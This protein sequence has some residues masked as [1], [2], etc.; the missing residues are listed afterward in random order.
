[1]ATIALI[2]FDLTQFANVHYCRLTTWHG[3][4][5]QLFMIS[6][7]SL[8]TIASAAGFVAAAQPAKAL[9]LIGNSGI[10]SNAGFD[11]SRK[12]QHAI[13]RLARTGGVLYLPAGIYI[14]NQLKL[15]AGV[16]LKGDTGQTRIVLGRSADYLLKM[17]N[18]KNTVIDGIIFDGNNRLL[19]RSGRAALVTA[20][21]CKDLMIKNCGITNSAANGLFLRKCSGHISTSNFSNC[22]SSAIYSLDSKALDISFNNIHDIGDNGILVWQSEKREDGSRVHDNTISR[23]FAKSGG[24]GPYGNGVFIWK[25]GSVSVSNNRISDCE[26]SAIRDNSGNNVTMTG[27]NCARLG[28]VALYVEFAF[29]GAIVSDNLVDGASLGVS[30]TNFNDG[31]RLAICANNVI[32]NI[33]GPKGMAD[34]QSVGIAVEADTIVTGNIVENADQC[35]IW[36]GWGR[37]LRDVSATGN[38]VRNC[39]IGI[40]LSMAKGARNCLVANNIIRAAKYPIVGMDHQKI[41]T[42]DLSRG[43]NKVPSQFT[44]T[45]N[46]VNR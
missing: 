1:M 21:N 3:F 44:I 20:Q 28:E 27:N 11:Q 23:I 25:A 35:G 8:F 39:P 4:C 22:L 17:E 33:N 26:F 38:V 19:Q 12:I 14:A 29:D 6:R 13:N 16:Q 32:R 7:R 43:R 2:L 41:V 31:G 34:N 9:Q 37:Y 5:F 40:S 36:L 45:G 10:A 46:Q 15:P 30:I 24:D 18:S 42:G